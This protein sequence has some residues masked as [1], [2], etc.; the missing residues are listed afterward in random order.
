MPWVALTDLQKAVMLRQGGPPGKEKGYEYIRN[1]VS[2]RHQRALD[3]IPSNR[4]QRIIAWRKRIAN[5]RRYAR[6]YLGGS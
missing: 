6:A 5:E 1:P 2:V 4:S 3:G